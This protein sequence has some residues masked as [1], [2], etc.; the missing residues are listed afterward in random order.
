MSARRAASKNNAVTLYVSDQPGHIASRMVCV[1][2]SFLD[3]PFSIVDVSNEEQLKADWYG[4]LNAY[5]N[6][7]TLTDDTGEP[8]C[9]WQSI[10]L[11]LITHY[12]VHTA[13]ARA[14]QLLPDQKCLDGVFWLTEHVRRCDAN[15]IVPLLR[16]FVVDQRLG[17]VTGNTVRFCKQRKE[18]SVLDVA[19]L[20]TVLA[21]SKP[22]VRHAMNELPVLQTLLSQTSWRLEPHWSDYIS[23]QI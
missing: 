23:S 21:M 15:S 6:L 13:P 2:A 17:A 19:F 7:P 11:H 12:G 16:D 5:R 14:A 3:I 20:T 1:I 4:R 8:L 22:T 9:T 10:I 18:P